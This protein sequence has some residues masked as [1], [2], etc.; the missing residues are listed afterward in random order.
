MRDEIAAPPD[1]A[2]TVTRF[3]RLAAERPP[4]LSPSAV[5]G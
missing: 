4:L 2:C 5:V 1:P 3:E